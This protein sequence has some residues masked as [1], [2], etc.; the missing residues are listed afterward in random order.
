MKIWLMPKILR[1]ESLKIVTVPEKP[2]AAISSNL[3]KPPASKF[4]SI[5]KK[6]KVG[7]KP[8]QK[9]FSLVA[10]RIPFPAKI[11]SSNHFLQ[12]I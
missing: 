12:F 8:Y 1:K 9:R 4:I 6:I 10:S 5:A 2:V 3:E 11:K 7:T